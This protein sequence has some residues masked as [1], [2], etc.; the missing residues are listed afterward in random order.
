MHRS[1][2]TSSGS[3]PAAWHASSKYGT[4]YFS[5][6]AP[7]AAAGWTVPLDVGIMLT[8]RSLGGCSAAA[9]ISSS[10]PTSRL[11]AG[12]FGTTR[13]AIP[14]RRRAWSRLM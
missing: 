5:A 6:A 7:I 14:S 9:S 13:I 11:P 1:S 10:L 2:A 3:C 12:P 8:Q 4:L